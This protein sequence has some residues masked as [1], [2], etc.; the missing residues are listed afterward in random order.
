MQGWRNTMED[1]HIHKLDL[2]N[3]VHIFGVFDGHGGK[4]VALFVEK[5]FIDELLKNP[6]YNQLKFKEALTETFINMD[7]MLLSDKG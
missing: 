3:D 6:N 1:A 5:Y 7:K 2:A 4:E